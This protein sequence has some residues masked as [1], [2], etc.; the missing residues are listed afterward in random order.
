M[1]NTFIVE[2]FH[3]KKSRSRMVE[4]GNKA[5]GKLR[6]GLRLEVGEPSIMGSVESRMNVFHFADH[7]VRHEVP[8]DFV[9]V[10]CNA[11]F[12]SVILQKVLRH[13]GSS[14]ALHCFDSF[15]G[16]PSSLSDKDRAAYEPGEMSAS[17]QWFE[18]NFR[19]AGLELPVVHPGWFE[20]TLGRGLPERVSF[21]LIDADLYQSTRTAL[22]HVY[23]RLSKGAVCMFG[24]YC[25]DRIYEPPTRSIKYQSPGVKAATDEFLADKP[26]RVSVL[27]SGAY[28]N[29]YFYKQ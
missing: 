17:R 18:D 5:L 26:E 8:G 1:H 11:G 16:L 25:D 24:V 6:L 28:S 27:Y 2:H 3:W 12:S 20:D 14:R 4:L 21:A 9:E 22:E 13:Y 10:G 19:A 7:A 23:P 29:G 15:E